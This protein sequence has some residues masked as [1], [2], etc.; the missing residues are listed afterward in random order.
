MSKF[1][2]GDVVILQT[3]SACGHESSVKRKIA[4]VEG[5]L[6]YIADDQGRKVTNIAFKLSGNEDSNLFYGN[7]KSWIAPFKKVA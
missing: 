4:A 6:V 5:N 2:P 1:Q 7:S 3:W